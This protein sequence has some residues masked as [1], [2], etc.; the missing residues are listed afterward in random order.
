MNKCIG[1]GD[2]TD[3]ILCDRCF[4]IRHYNDYKIVNKTNDEFIKILND[5]N[6]TNDLVVLVVDLFNIKDLKPIRKILKNDILLVLTKKDILPNEISTNIDIEV[7]DKVIVSS[8]KNYQFDLLKEKINK[9]KKSNNVYF[10]GYTNSGKSTLINKFIYNYTDKKIELTTSILPN[11]TLNKIE[12]KLDDITLI[13]TPGIID[14]N[15]ISNFV[16]KDDLKKIIPKEKIKPITYQIK[17]KQYIKIDNYA[18]LEVN[19]N[20]TLYF[21]RKLEIKRYYKKI[22]TDLVKHEINYNKER[23]IIDGLGFITTNTKGKMNIYTI[24]GVKITKEVI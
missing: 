15:D 10:V 3:K 14:Y 2:L 17:N 13:D 16:T 6:K 20:V 22:D 9:Y 19:T 24:K 11:T 12:V 18:L 8:Y 4:R 21:S 1:C 23:I 7:I 5:I